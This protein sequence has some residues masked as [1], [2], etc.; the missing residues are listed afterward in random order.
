MKIEYGEV[1]QEAEYRGTFKTVGDRE[2][3]KIISMHL[4]EKMSMAEKANSL[5]RSSKTIL[6]HIHSHN[7]SVERSGFCPVCRRDR[8]N[9]EFDLLRE[10]DEITSR[11]RKQDS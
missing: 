4:T 8:S 11:K 2:H 5:N 10:I 9:L 3:S 6:D 1:L 7:S